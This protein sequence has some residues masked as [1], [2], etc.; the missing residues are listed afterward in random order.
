MSE[1]QAFLALDLKQLG[2][3]GILALYM[4]IN[5]A[6][7]WTVIQSIRTANKQHVF[8]KD[9]AKIYLFGLLSLVSFASTWYYML[10][11]L[12]VRANLSI[13]TLYMAHSTATSGVSTTMRATSRQ[14][15]YLRQ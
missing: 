12:L 4:G 10:R 14:Q 11:F 3:L 2:A 1:L 15:A 13:C 5:V 9:T 8:K 6:L 7:A